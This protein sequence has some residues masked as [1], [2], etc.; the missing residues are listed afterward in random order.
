MKTWIALAACAGALGLARPA[1]AQEP[2]AA[3]LA[4]ARE[5]IAAAHDSANF[6]Q[7]F[8]LGLRRSLPALGDDSTVVLGAIGTW[9][10]K[11]M[12]WSTLAPQYERLYAQFYTEQELHEIATFLRSPA[13]QKMASVTPQ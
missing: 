3:H 5:L 12:R 9:S 4:A 13:G 6:Y 7:A 1:R 10:Q 11:Y 2:T 8:E